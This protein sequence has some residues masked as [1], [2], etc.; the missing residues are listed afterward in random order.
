MRRSIRKGLVLWLSILLGTVWL[1]SSVGG[2]CLALKFAGEAFD[3]ELVNSADS[4]AARVRIKGGRVVVDLPPAAQ[5]I[6]RHDNTDRF[7]YQVLSSKGERLSGDECLPRPLPSLSNGRPIFNTVRVGGDDLRIVQL[8]TVAEGLN[9][10]VIIQ[11]AETMLSRRQ[12]S[13]SILVTIILPQL[14]MAILGASAVWFGISAGLQPLKQLQAAISARTPG[15]LSS[16]SD[17]ISP[18]ETYPLVKAINGLLEILRE[19]AQTKQRFI[20]NASHQLRTPLAGL[21]TYS[22]LGVKTRTLDE[23]RNMMEQIDKGLDRT[24]HL[25]SQLLVL[26]RNDSATRTIAT[27]EMID[28]NFVA[29]DVV[30]QHINQAIRKNIDIGFGPSE[31]SALITGDR[32]GIHELVGNLVDNAIKY[33]PSGGKVIVGLDVSKENVTLDVRDTGC[34]IPVKDRDRIF[35][36]FYR[37]EGASADG[38]GLGLAIVRDVANHHGARILVEAGDNGTGSRFKV[39]FPSAV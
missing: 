5:A 15:D 31:K 4:V 29:S 14:L 23:M 17:A 11:V 39:V 21:K 18:E 10:E 34:G 20:A 38:S 2:Y 13:Q 3:R 24:S 8:S 27:D 7:Y 16:I 36:R 35:E 12:L 33:T 19:D 22:S 6:L 9:E 25:I 32:I 37:V 26:A 30:E 1:I 28:L